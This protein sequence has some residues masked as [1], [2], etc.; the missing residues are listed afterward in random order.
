MIRVARD[1]D[2]L[3]VRLMCPGL[4]RELPAVLFSQPNVCNKNIWRMGGEVL[5]RPG[6]GVL[7]DDGV[8]LSDQQ[9]AQGLSE[10]RIVIDQHDLTYGR[11]RKS[12]QT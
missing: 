7:R 4:L 5:D 1:D 9:G 12:I 11:A 6:I 3:Q 10:V 8:A 2:D